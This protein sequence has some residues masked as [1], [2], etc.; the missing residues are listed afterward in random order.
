L[1]DRWSPRLYSYLYY[2]TGEEIAARRL[3][4]LILSEVIHTVLTTPRVRN[5]SVLI[6]SI[7]HRH[8]LHYCRQQI[9][10]SKIKEGSPEKLMANAIAASDTV[11]G[12]FFHR[13]RQFPLETKQI[14][15]LRYVCGVTLLELSQIVG[16]PEEVLLQTIK[17]ANIYFQ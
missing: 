11:D 17:R 12:Y 5:L 4:H 14:L 1:I 3:L 8:T 2:N 16:Q 6:F 7:A 15:L 13:F 9:G 10:N